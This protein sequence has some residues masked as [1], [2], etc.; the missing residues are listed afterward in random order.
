[1]CWQ[2]LADLWLVIFSRESLSAWCL[3]ASSCSFSLCTVFITSR[4]SYSLRTSAVCAILSSCISCT[5]LQTAAISKVQSD[6]SHSKR[7]LC[8]TITTCMPYAGSCLRAQLSMHSMH[9]SSTYTSEHCNLSFRSFGARQLSTRWQQKI[10][11]AVA[12]AFCQQTDSQSCRCESHSGQY[13]A[14]DRYRACLACSWLIVT[15][16]AQRL[17]LSSAAPDSL[18]HIWDV[19]T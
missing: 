18:K 16:T 15:Y 12:L 8:S 19:R 9:L 7:I 2:K 14:I 5:C 6:T 13:G 3:A 17:T 11:L 10:N 1:M 4:Q